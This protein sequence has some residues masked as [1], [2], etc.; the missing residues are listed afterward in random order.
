MIQ[1]AI[2]VSAVGFLFALSACSSKGDDD[3]T[4]GAGTGGTSTSGTGGG[5]STGGS[6]STG[7]GTSTGG[8][9]PGSGGN[10]ATGG[11]TSTGGSATGGT[12]GTTGGSGGMSTGGSSGSSGMSTG[13]SSTGT[14]CEST[15]TASAADNYTFSSNLTINVTDVQPLPGPGQSMLHFDWSG[16]KTDLLG[17]PVDLTQIGMVEIGLWNLTLA[18]FEKKL[19]DDT[20]AQ[21]D[22]AIIATIL[23]AMP[24]ATTGNIYDLT[25][26]GQKL[27][28]AQI[29]PYLDIMTYPPGNNIYTAMVA[30]GMDLGKNT[31]MIQGFQL[32]AQSTNTLVTI[33]S[34]STK[35]SMTADLHS[36]TSP[37]VAAGNPAITIDWSKVMKTAAGL[38][39]DPT[40]ITELRVGKYTLS[41]TDLEM[42]SNFLNL[43]TIADTMYT[44]AITAGTSFDLSKAKDSNG[45]PFPGIDDAHTWIVALNCGDCANPAPWYLTVLK[46][47]AATK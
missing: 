45:N 16:L 7:G 24:G 47:C 34:N 11:G 39:F 18:Q 8:S 10:T 12:S 29:D 42:P 36:L 9:N 43:D 15:I 19:N 13:G 44:A 5:T 46:S 28:T 1:R 40:Q 22:L 17:H 38:T 6:T 31:R 21:T 20:L 37:L 14:T 33:D 3:T 41:A 2:Q 23:P 35:L 32:N 25:E 26:T 27:T 4:N 30:N